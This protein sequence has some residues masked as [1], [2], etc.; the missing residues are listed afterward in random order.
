MRVLQILL[1]LLV[2]AMLANADP[3]QNGS[4]EIG[5]A[6]PVKPCGCA[7]GVPYIGTFFAPYT[8]ITG[9]TVT[10]G[11]VDIIFPPGWA[12]SDGNRSIDLDGLSAG[13]IAQTLT[14]HRARNT[15]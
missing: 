3:F 12:A 5:P 4:F 9:W 7:G 10:S 6:G 1:I 11:S 14:P 8:G 2:A 13:T 15:K